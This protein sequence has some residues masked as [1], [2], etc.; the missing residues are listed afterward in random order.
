MMNRW[1]T[2][3]KVGCL[4]VGILSVFMSGLAMAS[5]DSEATAS[6]LGGGHV[7]ET[8]LNT[9]YVDPPF[10]PDGVY[11]SYV[12]SNQYGNVYFYNAHY[13]HGY[14]ARQNVMITTFDA[15]GN[16]VQQITIDRNK[17][18]SVVLT[19]SC[20]YS[21]MDYIEY[22]RPAATKA[23]KVQYDGEVS[24]RMLMQCPQK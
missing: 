21:T 17:P 24:G 20:Q 1:M 3:L 6:L 15:Y 14:I 23:M 10:R 2:L 18:I 12:G 11:F 19:S 9:C 22:S 16:V 13:K 5:P 8:V 7:E 4:Q